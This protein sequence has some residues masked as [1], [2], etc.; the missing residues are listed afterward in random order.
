MWMYAQSCPT[1]C[2]LMDYS[3]PGSSVHGLLQARLLGWVAIPLSRRSY[4]SRDWTL[5]PALTGRF[6]TSELHSF[7]IPYSSESLS[8]GY[9][10]IILCNL[11][12]NISNP[13][14]VPTSYGGVEIEG[15][16]WEE[17]NI[18]KSKIFVRSMDWKQSHISWDYKIYSPQSKR[19]HISARKG[20]LKIRW[21]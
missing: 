17:M 7:H 8:L 3:P 6:F 13:H 15:A 4:Q 9:L 21:S 11:F 18:L 1:L 14:V 5:S 19:I 16:G 12:Q 10:L 2:D 20:V